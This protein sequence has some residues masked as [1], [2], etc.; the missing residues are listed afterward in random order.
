MDQ[1][2]R[3]DGRDE[4]DDLERATEN[5][6]GGWPS[7]QLED[8]PDD[9]VGSPPFDGDEAAAEEP[10]PVASPELAPDE[11]D[12]APAEDATDVV[13][14]ATVADVPGVEAT[15]EH[16][17]GDLAV[18]PGYAVLEGEARG[19]RRAVGIVVSRFNG[20]VTGGLL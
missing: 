17:P 6:L 9:P 18:P 4:Q 20:E 10:G 13:G 15:G 5:V 8:P 12:E 1:I 11:P 7:A 3:P 16:A 2:D 19:A 14:E